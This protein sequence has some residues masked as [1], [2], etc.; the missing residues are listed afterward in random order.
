MA[1]LRLLFVLAL[2]PK[3]A[4]P[5]GSVA[6][7]PNTD[8]TKF[9]DGL[10]TYT[11]ALKQVSAGIVDPPTFDQFLKACGLKLGGPL[12]DFEHPNIELGGTRKF[13][14]RLRAFALQLVGKDSREFGD[15]VVPTPAALDSVEYAIELVEL[16]WASLLR[17]VPFTEYATN[18]T[19]QAAAHELSDLVAAHPGKYA[20]P[21]DGGKVTPDTLFLGGINGVRSTTSRES[22]MVHTI[23]V[24]LVP[25]FL[26]RV[27]LPEN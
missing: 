17:D 11:K 9:P 22:P 3:R 7:T 25:T 5:T 26:G 16:Y 4:V 24:C 19:A 13:N 23:S 14:G 27:R 6:H 2:R 18:A 20:G 21:L 10:G 12:G 8:L 1:R 15:A